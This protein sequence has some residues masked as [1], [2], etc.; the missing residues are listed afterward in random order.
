MTETIVKEAKKIAERIIKYETRKYLGKVYILWSTYPLI[1]TLFY[2]IIVDYFPS[3][4][5]DKFFTFSFQAL[6]IGLY[7]VIIYM[8]IRKLVITTLR[9]NG[10]Y[11]KG[12]KK[13]SRIV[14]PLLWSLIILVTLVMFLGYYTSDILLAVSGSSIYTVFVIYSFYDSLRIV[15]I[16]YYDVLALASFAIGM[17]AIPFGIYLPFYIMSVF[18]IYAGY[19]SLVEVIEDE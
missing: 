12:S 4:Y 1:I 14:T 13:R 8:L 18:W 11:G 15:G 5:N 10:I 17:M 6:L 16:K 2:S 19:K 3:L 7:F 9:Y